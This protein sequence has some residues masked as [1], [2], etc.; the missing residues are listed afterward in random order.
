MQKVVLD[1]LCRGAYT[2]PSI[3]V[4][5]VGVYRPQRSGFFGSELLA[6]AG[7]GTSPGATLTEE[8]RDVAKKKAV[9][10]TTS[11]KKSSSKTGKAKAAQKPTVKKAVRK[12][13]TKSSASKK[14][15]KKS[16]KKTVKKPAR[17]PAK[18]AT[19]KA[20]KKTAK[21]PPPKAASS[22]AKKQTASK[23]RLKKKIKSPLSPKQL[24]N[25]REL[26]LEKRKSLLGDMNGIQSTTIGRNLQESSGDLSNMPTHQAD[27]GSD[28]YEYEF[29][30]G[31][32]ESERMLLREV[33]EALER[34]DEGTYGVCLGTGEPIGIPRL[35]A[36]PWCKYCIEYQKM[37]EKGLVRPGQ[38]DTY[39]AL[40][41]EDLDEEEED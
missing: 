7:P 36:R 31:L 27:I 23:K 20:G 29:T 26:L 34:I 17:K 40:G 15:V 14:T 2:S 30:L 1:R 4:R 35:K 5:P 8:S 3:F 12:S 11:T 41:E 18:K 32:L 10:K 16:S 37:I 28:N 13:G 24:K 6:E 9:K 22:S 19:K 21:H 25:F 38:D 39:N 33:H